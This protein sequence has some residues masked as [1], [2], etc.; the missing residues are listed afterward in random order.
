MRKLEVPILPSLFKYGGYLIYFWS[1]END[2]PVH[3]H[4][5]KGKP[6]ANATKIWLT[7]AGGCVVAHNKSEIPAQD[8]RD[9][10][11]MIAAQ[12][13]WI[14]REWKEHFAMERIKFYC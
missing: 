12:H 4:V 10:M 6:S 8:L 5:S 2:E 9:I 13:F 14:C 3:V 1:N 7:N 11:E